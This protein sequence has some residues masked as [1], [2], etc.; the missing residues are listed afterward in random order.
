ML[1]RFSDGVEIDTDGPFRVR[2]F[3]DGWYVLGGGMLIP[4]TDELEG[5]A[6]MCDLRERREKEARD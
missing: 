5:H 4:C 3:A 6:I 2:E 1:I